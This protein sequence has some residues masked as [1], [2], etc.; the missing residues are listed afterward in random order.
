M[1]KRIVWLVASCLVGTTLLVTSCG[2]EVVEEEE[3]EGTIEAIAGDIWTVDMGGEIRTV[4]VSEAQIVGEPIAGRQV[5]VTGTVVGDAIAAVEAEVEEGGP[6]SNETEAEEGGPISTE[7]EEPEQEE[8]REIPEEEPQ[9]QE[10]P[11]P[12]NGE[13]PE[14]E[15]PREIP[16][17]EPQPQEEPRPINGEE[18][19][20]E[21]P[22]EI[23]EEEPEPEVPQPQG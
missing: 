3:F 22:R 8:P 5:W 6:I 7:T 20:Q 10:E 14:Q 17:E 18:P 19:E 13:E 23:P 15:E 1:R 4:D 11:R 9:P 12:I 21:E 2:P 16:E